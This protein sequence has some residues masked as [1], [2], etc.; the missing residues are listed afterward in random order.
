MLDNDTYNYYRNHR[1]EI[2][3]FEK[4]DSDPISVAKRL[5]NLYATNDSYLDDVEEAR[6]EY[7][8]ECGEPEDPEPDKNFDKLRKLHHCGKELHGTPTGADGIAATPKDPI[9]YAIS[10]NDIA[11]LESYY[12]NGIPLS[13][14]TGDS[15]DTECI[16]WDDQFMDEFS[17]DNYRLLTCDGHNINSALEFILSHCPDKGDDCEFFPIPV[18]DLYN[19]FVSKTSS[20]ET[21]FKL[22]LD[23]YHYTGENKDSELSYFD[24]PLRSLL[25]YYEIL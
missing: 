6:R 14:I 20:D 2:L 5:T 24:M 12:K 21:I 15:E 3:Q 22:L 10:K 23:Y 17:G 8:W 16:P 18:F 13:K 1:D 25:K 9:A 11:T 19:L 4:E 7:E